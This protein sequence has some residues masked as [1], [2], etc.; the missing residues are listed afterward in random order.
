MSGII[1]PVS[2]CELASAQA[3]TVTVQ[4]YGGIPQASFD[5]AY[6]LNGGPAV[7]ETVTTSGLY[8]IGDVITHNLPDSP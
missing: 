4:N 3:V 2:I 7:T 8:N 1:S 6:T 5:I